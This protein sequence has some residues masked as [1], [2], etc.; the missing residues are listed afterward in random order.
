M[1]SPSQAQLRPEPVPPSSFGPVTASVPRSHD[2][3]V[4][5]PRIFRKKHTP[6]AGSAHRS[7]RRSRLVPM[8]TSRR[9]PL[10]TRTSYP[11]PRR[12]TLTPHRP[13]LTPVTLTL[14]ESATIPHDYTH[15]DV[16]PHNT[17]HRYRKCYAL[18]RQYSP[19]D[20]GEGQT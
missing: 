3:L 6:A 11:P 14:P 4:P 2:R 12:L 9:I 19:R 20:E 1:L 10:Y 13:E 17:H 7:H 16:N 15:K 8:Y 18:S 5:F